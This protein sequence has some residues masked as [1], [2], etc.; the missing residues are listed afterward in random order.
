MA[1]GGERRGSPRSR[2]RAT[3]VSL[4]AE[5]VAGDLELPG[6]RTPALDGVD[7]VFL[8]GGWSDMPGIVTRIEDAGARRV[9]LLTSRCVI[10]GKPERTARLGQSCGRHRAIEGN[11]QIY[12]APEGAWIPVSA[13]C[14]LVGP[15][16]IG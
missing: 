15:P 8:F 14:R 11:D 2:A 10:G 16:N 3:R 12:L 13:Q 4:P 6:S 7:A 9:V 1:V 5:V